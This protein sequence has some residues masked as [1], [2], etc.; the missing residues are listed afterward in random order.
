MT[1]LSAVE[2]RRTESPP[3]LNQAGRG[4]DK[5][6]CQLLITR[7]R[8]SNR[9]CKI[10]LAIFNVSASLTP[11]ETEQSSPAQVALPAHSSFDCKKKTVSV[12]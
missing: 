8:A 10:K 5:K 9:A 2:N 12:L 11:R 7:R 4:G 1:G 3:D 6:P